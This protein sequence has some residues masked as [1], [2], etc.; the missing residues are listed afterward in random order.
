MPQT[1]SCRDLFK[2]LKILTLT[3]VLIFELS[4]YIYNNKHKYKLGSDIYDI[5]TRQKNTLRVPYSRLNLSKKSPTHLAV[6]VIKKLSEDIKSAAHVNQFKRLLKSYLL[7]SAFYSIN[8]Y[9]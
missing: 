2:K 8:D 9:L 1:S 5:N 3:P 6:T 4:V 7:E